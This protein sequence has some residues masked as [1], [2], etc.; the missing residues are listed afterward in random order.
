MKMNPFGGEKLPLT[1]SWELNSKN[2]WTQFGELDS[3]RPSERE[4]PLKIPKNRK[5]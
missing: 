3:I 2:I 4:K 5:N 1:F